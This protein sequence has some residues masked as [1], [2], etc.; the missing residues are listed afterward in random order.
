MNLKDNLKKIR[1][2]NNLSQEDLAEKLNVSRQSVSKW[3]QG[4]AYPEMDKVIQ[5]CNMFNLNIDELLNQDITKVEQTKQSKLNVNKYIDDFLAFITKTIKMFGSMKFKDKVKCLIEQIFIVLILII[6]C[7]IIGEIL[8][9]IFF[10]V[11]SFIHG[12][13]I[14]S[15]FSLFRGIYYLIYTVF[16]VIVLLHIFKTRYL[17]YYEASNKEEIKEE[18]KTDEEE[19]EPKEKNTS[20]K[21][22]KIIIRDPKHSGYRFINGIAKVLLFLVKAFVFFIGLCFCAALIAFVML[23][24]GSFLITKTGLLFVG[25]LLG[26]ISGI[27]LNVLIIYMIF[28]FLANLKINKKLVFLGIIVTLLICGASFGLMGIGFKD[29]KYIGSGDSKYLVT[30]TDEVEMDKDLVISDYRDVKYVESNNKNLKIEIKHSNLMDAEVMKDNNMMF[31]V[32]RMNDGA[33]IKE[34]IKTINNKI[35][36]DPDY[37]SVTIYTTKA[38]IKVLNDNLSKYNEK[39]SRIDDLNN[40]IY[41]LE[42]DLSQKQNDIEQKTE[43]LELINIELENRR[44]ELDSMD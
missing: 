37:V 18:E 20:K 22:E 10:N 41:E 23:L 29:F 17:D 8:S 44:K 33:P 7:A 21:E 35:I 31:F 19:K 34:L 5:I 27:I 9:T 43:E 30:T 1:K 13:A 36:I 4:L 12:D 40:K 42:N 28:Y 32:T 15:V 26:S 11:F 6:G 25:L 2:D 39:I 16:G 38:N 3:E 14:Y 24:V